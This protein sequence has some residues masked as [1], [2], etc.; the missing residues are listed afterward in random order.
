[1]SAPYTAD[2]LHRFAD[3]MND[4]GIDAGD[5]FAELYAEADRLEKSDDFNTAPCS[6]CGQ[7]IRL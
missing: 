3:W 6:H 2:E 4:R 5:V 7:E 1:M